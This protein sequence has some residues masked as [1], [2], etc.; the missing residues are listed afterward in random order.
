V[1]ARAG[2][3]TVVVVRSSLARGRR[4]P[5]GLQSG[6]NAMTL[7]PW[8]FLCGLRFRGEVDSA[9]KIFV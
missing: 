2:G 5:L 9:G 1:A 8:F 6:R 4:L 3:T 7:R